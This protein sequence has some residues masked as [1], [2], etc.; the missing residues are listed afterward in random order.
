MRRPIHIM[1]VCMYVYMYICVCV[2]THTH[3]HTHTYIHTYMY[4]YMYMC[5][6]VYTH[7]HIHTHTYT[8]IHTYIHNMYRA[9]QMKRKRKWEK[10]SVLADAFSTRYLRFFLFFW[11]FLADA[12]S[13]RYLRCS[14]SLFVRKSVHFVCKIARILTD[15]L[16]L[17]VHTSVFPFFLVRRYHICMC[18]CVLYVLFGVVVYTFDPVF[19]LRK[20]SDEDAYRREVFDLNPKP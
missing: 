19:L 9:T 13:T 7:T 2:H 16:C 4:V 20:V 3:T 6:C 11:F 17:P 15:V 8:Y 14:L 1:Y 12:F 10:K 5:V 18:V